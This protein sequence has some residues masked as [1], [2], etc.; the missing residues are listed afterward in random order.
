[1]DQ[2]KRS[3]AV[4]VEQTSAVGPFQGPELVPPYR[5]VPPDAIEFVAFSHK[6]EAAS[7]DGLFFFNLRR[8]LPVCG[9]RVSNTPVTVLRN[10][11][12]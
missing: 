9:T 6:K 11:N 4:G 2:T 1:M 12:E 5:R 7:P 3:D 10:A 8:F